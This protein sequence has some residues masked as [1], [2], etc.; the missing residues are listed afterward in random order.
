MVQREQNKSDRTTL[1]QRR[2]HVLERLAAF[3]LTR[4]PHR[5][6]R[7]DRMWD[8]EASLGLKLRLA[9]SDLGPIFSSLDVTLRRVSIFYRQPIVSNSKPYRTLRL[10]CLTQTCGS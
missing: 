4:G 10:R 1:K 2:E 3:G 6:V 7:H 5:I 8:R 9:L